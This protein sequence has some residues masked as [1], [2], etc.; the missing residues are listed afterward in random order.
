MIYN[1][2]FHVFLMITLF[3][4]AIFF[5]SFNTNVRFILLLYL[6]HNGWASLPMSK[7]IVDL[8]FITLIV[9]IFLLFILDLFDF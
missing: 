5:R 7:V 3:L 6:N 9:L 1:Y 8:L 4:M 2:Q